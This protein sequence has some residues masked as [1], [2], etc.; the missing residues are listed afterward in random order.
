MVWRCKTCK[1]MGNEGLYIIRNG[2]VVIDEIECEPCRKKRVESRW[3]YSKV[4]PVTVL[5]KNVP[6]R[7]SKNTTS[8]PLFFTPKIPILPK[9]N[10]DYVYVDVDKFSSELYWIKKGTK[11]KL[12]FYWDEHKVLRLRDIGV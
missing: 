10:Q 11:I 1:K 3:R 7:R 4:Y 2:K 6:G 12:T 5:G 9:G 8:I